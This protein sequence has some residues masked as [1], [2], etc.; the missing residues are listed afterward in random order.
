MQKVF[1]VLF[2]FI[3]LQACNKPIKEY[4][5][6]DGMSLQLFS[7]STFVQ[8]I[9]LLERKY[10]VSGT[11]SGSLVEGNYFTTTTS[12]KGMQGKVI[13][14]YNILNKK[15]IPQVLEGE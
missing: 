7:D 13:T 14:K 2:L 11:W 4:T 6:N 9:R 15:A 8:D 3:A 5:L 12:G 1:T 10:N